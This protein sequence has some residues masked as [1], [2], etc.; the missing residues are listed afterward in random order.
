MSIAATVAPELPLLRRFA[1]LLTGSQA[2]GDAYV[3]ATLEA[4]T[5]DPAVFL[6]QLPPRQAL[7]KI[8]LR[9]WS[10]ALPPATAF[11]FDLD[12]ANTVERNL[13][14]ITPLPRQAFLL[15]TVEGFSIAEVAAILDKTSI[16][17]ADL[18]AQAGREI[19][20]QVAT[21]VLIIEDEPIIAFDIE[22]MVQ[23]L[24][25][26][27]TGIARTHREAVE[28]VRNR[29]PGLVLADIL[30]ADGSSGLDA[31]NEILASIDVP[32][33]F[34]T[35]FPERLLTGERPEPTYLVTKP[36]QPDTVRATISQALF[37]GCRTGGDA[38]AAAASERP[39]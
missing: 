16:E 5:V 28:S 20:D 2:S 39:A 22:A 23:E 11:G 12:A 27:V 37:F 18:V 14:A 19:A 30:L 34:I 1:R 31:V 8:F 25:H 36:F 29:K 6:S 7:Y 3:V 17:V 10:S 24:G 33:V 9:L 35:A 38:A 15:R 4:L 13:G 32:V 21:E 26:D